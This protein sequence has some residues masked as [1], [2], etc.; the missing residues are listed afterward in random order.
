MLVGS[1][2]LA[3]AISGPA[4]SP[5][6]LPLA[7]PSEPSPATTSTAPPPAATPPPASPFGARPG[8]F[9]TISPA[10]LTPE[11]QVSPF[12]AAPGVFPGISPAPSTSATQGQPAS[13]AP[14]VSPAVPAVPTIATPQQPI[15]PLEAQPGIATTPGTAAPPLILTPGYGFGTPLAPIGGAAAA[16]ILPPAPPTAVGLRPLRPGALPVQAQDLRAPPILIIPRATLIESYTDNPRNTPKGLSD[17]ITRLNAGTAISVDS[18]RLQ[19][20]LSGSVDYQK[21]ARATDLDGLNA[22][23]L[24]F[25]LGTVVRDHVFIDARAAI[26]QLSRSGGVGFANSSVIPRSQQTQAEV[27]SLSPIARGS[28][29]DFVDGEFR[30][31]YSLSLFQNGG[32]LG[33]SAT[34]VPAT[35]TVP[36][37]SLSNTSQN[38][39]TLS[40]ATGRRFTLLS[41]RLTLDATEANSGPA[42]ESTQLRAFDDV[43][44]QFNREFAALARAGYEDFRFPLQPAANRKGMIW[45]IGGRVTPFPGSYLAVRYGHENGGSAATG[46]LRYEVTPATTILGSLQQSLG[47]TQQQILSNLNSSQIDGAGN[48]VDSVTGLPTSLVN[49]Q[50]SNASNTIFRSENARIG[51]QTSLDRDTFG[52]FGFVDQRTP[53]GTPTGATG[54]AATSSV[55]DTAIGA[56]LYW[57][58][59]L[60]PNLSSAATLGYATARQSNT[61]TADLSL[62]YTISQNLTGVVHYQFINVDSAIVAGSYRR[63]LLEIGVTRSF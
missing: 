10:P 61:L 49:P 31:N 36:S 1:P 38:Q 53:V 45:L 13:P 43:E 58:R 9:P 50:F 27:I 55:N 52:I 60:T 59:S 62:N 17:S 26:T 25:G 8:V 47:S 56:N 54:V 24:G 28:I 35:A 15:S 2:A 46:E 20:Q 44:Y 7:P 32:F 51:I 30:Y 19:G 4:A 39:A 29:S 63:N 18:V 16:P 11:R 41:S 34:T 5:G 22:N 21:Y 42:A 12:G 40:L 33:N 6:E 3:Q 48:L 37:T 14:G 23:L 57:S